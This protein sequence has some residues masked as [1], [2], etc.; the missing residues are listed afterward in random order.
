MSKFVVEQ[1]VRLALDFNEVHSVTQPTA[2][3]W[4]CYGE[5]YIESLSKSR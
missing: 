3:F 1:V 2:F 5:N 4:H